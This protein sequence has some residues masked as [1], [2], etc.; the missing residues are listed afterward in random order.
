MV[1]ITLGAAQGYI[2]GPDLW[3]VSY[4]D[5]LRIEMSANTFLVGHTDSCN[6]GKEHRDSPAKVAT[7][8]DTNKVMARDSLLTRRQIP[9]EIDMQIGKVIIP[10]EKNGEFS[11]HPSRCLYESDCNNSSIELIDDKYWTFNF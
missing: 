10:T 3:N 6:T 9:T 4:N 1:E 11:R 7:S 8:H 5:I 2:M